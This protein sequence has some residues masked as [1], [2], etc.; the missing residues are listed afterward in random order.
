MNTL[1]DELSRLRKDDP[2]VATVLDAFAE[3]ERIYHETLEAMGATTKHTPGIVNSAE[4]T[5]SF[6][7]GPYSTHD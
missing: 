7:P 4:V 6:R 1:T 2:D 5:L 3:I